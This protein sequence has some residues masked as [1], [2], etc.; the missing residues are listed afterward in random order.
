MSENTNLEV[1]G[2]VRVV[3]GV[4]YTA[5]GV[6]QISLLEWARLRV[7]GPAIWNIGSRQVKVMAAAACR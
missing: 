2:T 4:N 6:F 1:A 5:L 7:W 3:P